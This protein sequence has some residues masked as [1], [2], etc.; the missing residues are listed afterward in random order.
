MNF[1]KSKKVFVTGADGF[2]GGWLAKAL[3]DSGADVTII[4]RDI[5]KEKISI[6][7]HHIRDKVTIILG[8]I[9]DYSLV[10]RILNEHEIDTVFHLA[11]QAIVG[12][13]NRSPLSTFE[14]NI[15]GTWTILEAARVTSTVKRVIVASSDKA[16]GDQEKL[17]YTED[18]PLKGLYP[19]DASK[20]CA[21]ILAQSYFKTYHLPVCVTRNAN[22]YGGADLNMSRI[23]PDT[24]KSAL[25]D[26]ELVIRSDGTL[27][28][29]YIYVKDIVAAY[30]ILAENMDRNE[31]AG[32]AFNFG[33]GKPITVLELFST[34]IRLTNRNIKPKILNQAKNEIKKQYLSAEKAKQ[35]LH[36]QPTYSLEEGLKE[37]IEWYKNN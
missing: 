7:Y 36:W 21:D 8:D 33:T 17:P 13:A 5:K 28:R 31:I 37:T 2:I 23:V 27:E 32:Q 19:Y 3:V 24:I 16:Y 35:L 6:D 25:E 4:L 1:W 30:L 15:K 22:T 14:S 26:R 11:A 34:I 20:A 12:A 18:Q 29:D 10:S 9:I